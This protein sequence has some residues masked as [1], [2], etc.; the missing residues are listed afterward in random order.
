MST[1]LGS[2]FSI[3]PGNEVYSISSEGN[4]C[5]S[6]GP[7]LLMYEATLEAVLLVSSNAGSSNKSTGPTNL[8][9][10]IWK[11]QPMTRGG[12]SNLIGFASS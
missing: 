6:K 3:T 1:N 2:N 10:E 7:C 8:A 4:L 5:G 12:P 11:P 9:S